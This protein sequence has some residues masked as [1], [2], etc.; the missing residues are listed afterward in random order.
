VVRID[1]Y[2]LTRLYKDYSWTG[3]R[4]QSGE[5]AVGGSSGRAA[6]SG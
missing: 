3:L 2:V 1:Q 6:E 4:D 5:R